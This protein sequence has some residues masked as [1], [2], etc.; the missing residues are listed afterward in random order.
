MGGVLVLARQ[1]RGTR[2]IRI[3]DGGLREL[4]LAFAGMHAYAE[5][6]KLSQQLGNQSI[7][8]FAA[9]TSYTKSDIL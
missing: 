1:A 3:E 4:Q 7:K 8:S 2:D 6:T 9:K 5:L